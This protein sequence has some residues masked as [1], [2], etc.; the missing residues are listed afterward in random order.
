[1]KRTKTRQTSE[2]KGGGCFSLLGLI[3]QLY[4]F[5]LRLRNDVF[6]LLIC[7]SFARAHKEKKVLAFAR[8]MGGLLCPNEVKP[9]KTTLLRG[10]KAKRGPL[11]ITV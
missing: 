3:F 1:M 11:N 8:R 6:S 7:P 10:R 9:K 4:T 2:Q 5:F